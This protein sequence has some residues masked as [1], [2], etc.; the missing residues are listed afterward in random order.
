MKTTRKFWSLLT[1]V[2]VAS[3]MIVACGPQATEAPT[4]APAVP[5]EP[6][7][8]EEPMTEEPM[9]EEPA[10]GEIDCKGAAAGDEISMLYQWSGV[11]EEA[12]NQV[13]QPLIDACGIVLRPESTR[14]QAL[15][16]TRVQAGTPPDVAFWQVS[17]LVQYQDQL[18]P[19]DAL[20]ADRSS[21]GEFFLDPMTI[22]GS[23][24]VCRS[25]PTSNLSSG[26][27]RSTSMPSVIRFPPPG[28]SWMRWSSKWLLMAMYPG[29][30]ASSRAMPPAGPGPT[31][32]RTL[33]WYN[34]VLISSTVLST[35]AFRTMIPAS[36]QAYETYGTWATDE[37]IP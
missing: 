35:A 11:E 37:P 6:A 28:M 23:G 7:M 16:D 5:T 13:L 18:Q 34:R 36:A 4:T 33:C 17:Q 30:W 29:A 25:R 21:Y 20:G 24:W 14:D 3:M 10:M 27:A 26:I 12:L 2:I 15:L 22:D 8:T 9:T 1:L 32:F 19:M 31:L